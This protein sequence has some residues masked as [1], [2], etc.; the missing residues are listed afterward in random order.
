MML[1]E[2]Q[3][4]FVSAVVILL[5][6]II[7]I[8]LTI[9]LKDNLKKLTAIL[10]I[11]IL[12]HAVYQVVGFLGLTL[13]ADGVFEPLSVAVLIFFGIIY[14]GFAKPKNMG[15]KNSM[16]VVWNPGTLLLLMNS[17]TTLLLL[18]ALG[19]FVWLAV[20]SR[21]IRSFQFQISIFIIIW[22]LGE[23]TGILQDNGIIVLSALHGDVGLE[24][25]VISMVFFSMMLWLRFYY[26]KRSGKKMIEDVADASG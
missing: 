10:S 12:I 20:R 3:L 9:K 11:F 6:S 4:H 5:A 16:V 13:L 17:I 19:I 26:S 15:V 23:I 25:H 21:N 8:Y 24:I 22:I 1:G 7:P 18:V 2:T 14:S